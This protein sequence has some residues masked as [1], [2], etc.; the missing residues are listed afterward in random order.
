[1]YSLPYDMR[2]ICNN[3]FHGS[4]SLWII[5]YAH[6]HYLRCV[7]CQDI[8]T[9]MFVKSWRCVEYLSFSPQLANFLVNLFCYALFICSFH[10]IIPEQPCSKDRAVW[11]NELYPRNELLWNTALLDSRYLL[12]DA[13]VSRYTMTINDGMR[14][15]RKRDTRGKKQ[16]KCIIL[17]VQQTRRS[18]HC[19]CCIWC[20]AHS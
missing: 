9:F 4:L 15:E 2:G 12:I 1:M 19:I 3:C 20:G 17:A 11:T 8:N 10:W 5:Q 16:Q 13:Q 7:V 14:R 6:A 18:I